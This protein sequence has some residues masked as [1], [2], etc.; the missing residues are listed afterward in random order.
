MTP[1]ALASN[2][3]YLGV[4]SPLHSQGIFVYNGSIIVEN[5]CIVEHELEVGN[6]VV[7]G[8]V[9]ELTRG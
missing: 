7:Q 1:L 2:F 8:V 5:L 3:R 4:E 6:E 9:C